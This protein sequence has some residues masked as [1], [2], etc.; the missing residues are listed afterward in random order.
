MMKVTGGRTDQASRI[1]RASPQVIYRALLD[2]KAVAIW[3]PPDGMTGT[4]LAFDPREGGA[5]RMAFAYAAGDHAIAGKT[6]E[7]VDVF[8][9]WFVELIPDR[10]VVERVIFETDD[11]VFAGE[12][13]VTTTLD[14]VEAG[15]EVTIRC[16]DVPDGIR[17]ED[18]AVGLASTLA[19]LATFVEA[20]DLDRA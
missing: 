14:P 10:R 8:Q 5:F 11:P 3:R 6:S 13:T 17:S 18:H 7:H 4:V 19:N 2:P 20:S 1:I 15:T 16:D 9:G 12:M